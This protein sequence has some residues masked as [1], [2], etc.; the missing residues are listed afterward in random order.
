M[1]SHLLEQLLQKMC[2]S[3][4]IY[5][6]ILIVTCLFQYCI[7]TLSQGVI[8]L[9]TLAYFTDFLLREKK[10]SCFN[11]LTRYN[12]TGSDKSPIPANGNSN[13]QSL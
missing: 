3:L 7:N 5:L 10:K 9:D 8:I 1:C 6:T 2:N 12:F 4:F 13:Y 11:M